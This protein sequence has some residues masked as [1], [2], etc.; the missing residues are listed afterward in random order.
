M[1]DDLKRSPHLLAA[2]VAAAIL[3]LGLA[4]GGGLIGKG[5]ENEPN[6]RNDSAV[7]PYWMPMIL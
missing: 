2:S 6:S 5:V 4:A 7:R 3:G 1:L